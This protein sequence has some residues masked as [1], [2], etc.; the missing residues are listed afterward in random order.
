MQ[1]TISL[2]AA[3]LGERKQKSTKNRP[4]FATTVATPTADAQDLHG[5]VAGVSVVRKY[6]G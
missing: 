5:L 6:F 3:G 1:R 4:R 2:L